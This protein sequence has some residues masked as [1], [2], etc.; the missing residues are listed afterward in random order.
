MNWVSGVRCQVSGVCLSADAAHQHPTP[1][2]RHPTPR[3]G[4]TLVEL[5]VVILI[6]SILAAAVLGVA[7]IAGQTAREARTRNIVARLHSFIAQQVDSYKSRR[8]KV[9]PKVLEGINDPSRSSVPQQVKNRERAQARVYALRELMLMEMPQRWSDLLLADVPSSLNVSASSYR[10]P[11]YLDLPSV[12]AGRVP[13]PEL[14]DVYRRHFERICDS[15]NK[16][17]GM[18]N[19]LEQVLA[20]QGAECLYLIVINACADGEARSLIPESMIGD[21]DGDGALEF[22]DGWGRPIH[23]LRWAPGFNSEIQAN[24]SNLLD[25]N[26]GGTDVVPQQVTQNPKWEDTAARDHD[27]LDV[28]RVELA[29]FRLAP[30]IYSSGQDG[31][32]G[33]EESDSYLWEGI[34]NPNNNYSVGSPGNLTPKVSPYLRPSTS[35]PLYAGEVA[36]GDSEAK[37]AATDNIHNHLISMRPR[38]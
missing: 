13:R 27:P 6:I 29:A 33:I 14:A 3:S 38:R 9:R 10:Y 25:P 28:Q 34:S 21:T 1:D 30:L 12:G 35:P 31:E 24:A 5:L 32:V 17:S 36:A 37:R 20:N 15:N 4:L 2:T 19:T 7:A 8:V 22:L 18:P 26:T 16:I 23:F 11:Y